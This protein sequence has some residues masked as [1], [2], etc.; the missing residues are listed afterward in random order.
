MSDNAWLLWGVDPEA[1]QKAVAEAARLGVSLADYL[2]SVLRDGGA[3]LESAADAP[4]A[5]SPAPQDYPVAPTQNIKTLERRLTLAIGRL[6][7][8]AQALDNSFLGLAAR[9]DVAEAMA[10][11]T[12][13]ALNQSMSGVEGALSIV[14]ARLAEAE[15]ASE[16]L[17]DE[18]R[19]LRDALSHRL[20]GL[21]QRVAGAET[22]VRTAER[23]L[24]DLGEAHD[25]LK[26][27]VA[28]DFTELA[29]ATASRV[30]AGLTEMRAA[31][32]AAAEQAEAASAHWVSEMRALRHAVE[33]R[34]TESAAETRKRMQAAMADGAARLGALNERLESA[35]RAAQGLYESLRAEI[36]GAEGRVGAAV[37]ET[38]AAMRQSHASLVAE[39]AR[40]TRESK[41]AVDSARAELGDA[42]AAVREQGQGI[43]ARQKAADDSL[44]STN[45]ELQRLRSEMTAGFT[46][47]ESVARIGAT[48][49]QSDLDQRIGAMTARLAAAEDDLKRT[50][51][52]A[53]AETHRVETSTLAALEKIAGD[54]VKVRDAQTGATARLESVD[55]A[56]AS[57]N[58]GAAQLSRRM[59]K[60]ESDAVALSALN[61][62]LAQLE[63]GGGAHS[64][65]FEQALAS[66]RDQANALT[67]A[68]AGARR[69]DESLA[70]RM[71][72]L[73]RRIVSSEER[74]DGAARE[75]RKNADA[76][77]TSEAVER[78]I[79]ALQDTINKTRNESS[80]QSDALREIESRLA[81]WEQRQAD[82]FEA[83]RDGFAQFISDNEQRLQAIE[84]AP[85]L[86]DGVT[87]QI[88]A[89][90]QR[91]DQRIS[92][93]EQ[94]SVRALEQ[95]ADTMAVLEQ[96]FMHPRDAEAKSA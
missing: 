85:L 17:G 16:A 11:E 95:V 4:P 71:D 66:L 8:T 40:H 70:K 2:E 43:L 60:L 59:L 32:E 39:M 31:A 82:A 18:Q 58:A 89:F 1:R 81:A 92:D 45:D 24:G 79:L 87:A 74:A 20:A 91:V 28:D 75:A 67:A 10:A 34:L 26:R 96:R 76:P 94:R 41:A 38:S 64:D 65:E 86:D 47:A 93:V 57:M 29:E 73:Q 21:D 72:E 19:M 69:M 15:G 61:D 52:I 30:D 80:A 78:Q 84:A 3:A 7:S 55:N 63:Q 46:A 51:P 90:R 36:A 54:I 48:R 77:P 68:L 33:A 35:E 44:A 13:D 56:M 5:K 37:E 6:D 62:R 22:A 83:L 49:L 25:A 88:D 9:I 53:N 42:I 27:A 23:G 14:R 12:S 50:I